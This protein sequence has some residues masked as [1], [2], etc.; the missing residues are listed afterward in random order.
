MRSPSRGSAGASHPRAGR[1]LRGLWQRTAIGAGQTRPRTWRNSGPSSH[2][3]PSPRRSR[4]SPLRSRRG[5]RFLQ[6]VVDLDIFRPGLQVLGHGQETGMLARTVV[7]QL[8]GAFRALRSA[9]HVRPGC[10][11]VHARHSAGRLHVRPRSASQ[12]PARSTWTGARPGGWRR[13]APRCAGSTDPRASAA[14][15]SI[16]GS[17][18]I[19]LADE[20]GKITASP[21]CP[22]HGP[23]PSR[24]RSPH[25]QRWTHSRRPPRQ[26]S[27]I[28]TAPSLTFAI[29]SAPSFFRHI[30]AN[31]RPYGLSRH[32]PF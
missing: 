23:H 25:G 4:P 31:S 17:A 2:R 12:R 32:W 3:R 15:V 26:T 19:I 24:R 30:C 10:R 20:R 18:W 8:A 16:S 21:D 27:S 6:R 7:V 14:P 28:G 11:P 1:G 29:G 5:S 9:G 22:R 13:K